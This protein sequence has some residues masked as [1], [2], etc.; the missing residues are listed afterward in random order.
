MDMKSR[1][2]SVDREELMMRFR[3]VRN[4]VALTLIAATPGVAAAVPFADEIALFGVE[5]QIYPPL[6]CE[7]LFV[8]SSSFRFWSR[9]QQEFPNRK[10]L[11]RGFGGASIADINYHFEAVVGRY[12]PRQIIFYAGEND[13]NI[14]KPVASIVADFQTFLDLKTVVMGETPVLFV[15]V[16]PSIA[17]TADF[18]LQTELNRQVAQLADKRDDLDYVDI[19]EPMM[20]DGKPRSELFIS[21]KLHMNAKGYAI[22]RG[23]ISRLLSDQKKVKNQWCHTK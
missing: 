17:R 2:R 10:V 19:V 18:T 7:T 6:G 1:G 3:T 20:R 23:R 14:G 11:K 13:I 12:K 16:K 22:W 4:V 5:D 9:M 15:S 21:D 8:G